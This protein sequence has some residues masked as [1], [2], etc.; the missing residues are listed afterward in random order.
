MATLVIDKQVRFLQEKEVGFAKEDVLVVKGIEGLKDSL[1][2]RTLAFKQ[3]LLQLQGVESVSFTNPVPGDASFGFQFRSDENHEVITCRGMMM[4]EDAAQTLTLGFISGRGFSKKFNDTYSLLIN[5]KAVKTLGL[6]EPIGKRLQMI[7]SSSDSLQN[8]WYTVVG[9]IKDF[10]YQS[11]QQEIGPLI[12]IHT[13]NPMAYTPFML[14]KIQAGSNTQHVRSAIEKQWKG[15]Y[16]DEPLSSFY[17]EDYWHQ[18]LEGERANKQLFALFTGITLALACGGLFSLSA[19]VMSTRQK[20]V[21]IR[22]V[23]GA[24]AKDIM[25]LLSKDFFIMAVFAFLIAFPVSWYG[26]EEWLSSFAYR[27]ELRV[28]LF[29]VAGM[30]VIILGFSTIA[31]HLFK[32]IYHNPI[33]SL[34]EE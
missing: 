24:S 20:E 5:E 21:S 30:I 26:L 11:L 28:V 29:I 12:I 1:S 6:K 10:H 9:V 15:I 19:H 34:K 7:S 32:V 23:L 22:K 2:D 31:Y 3:V 4:D 25:L 18:L 14:V 13:D 27:I 17:L 8:D 16:P 33:K